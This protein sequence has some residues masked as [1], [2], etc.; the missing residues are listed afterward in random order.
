MV[1]ETVPGIATGR[2]HWFDLVER[3]VLVVFTAEYAIN[4]WVAPDRKAYVL[5]VWGIIDLLAVLPSLVLALNVGSAEFLGVMRVM[6]VLRILRVL[7]LAKVAAQ[8]FQDRQSRGAAR[9]DI[10]IY[11]IALFCSLTVWSTLVY[12]AERGQPAT[13]FTSI[14]E[15]MW[16]GISALTGATYGDIYPTTLW[17]RIVGVF[18]ALN[19]LALFGL[20]MNVIGEALHASLFGSRKPAAACPQCGAALAVPAAAG[21]GP[22]VAAR[23]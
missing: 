9:M 16:W 18:A 12:Y 7:K 17:G 1:L 2:Q 20:L 4:V 6:R 10:Q 22:A 14:P 3:L 21:G 11:F 8:C 13:K 19:G 15:G 23:A 5:G